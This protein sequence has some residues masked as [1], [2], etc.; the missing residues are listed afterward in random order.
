MES[1][2]EKYYGRKKT[3]SSTWYAIG[4]GTALYATLA[5]FAPSHQPVDQKKN[6]GHSPMISQ[7]NRTGLAGLL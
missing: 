7:R 2:T 4:I 5:F 1:L 3:P 6:E